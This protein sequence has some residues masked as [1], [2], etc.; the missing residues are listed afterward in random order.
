MIG[1]QHQPTLAIDGATAT[2]TA[3]TKDTPSSTGPVESVESNKSVESTGTANTDTEG[4]DR[5]TP[6]AAQTTPISPKVSTWANV[7]KILI[8][9]IYKVVM[10]KYT[11]NVCFNLLLY[12]T[13][14]RTIFLT[15][16]LT[17]DRDQTDGF[18]AAGGR[19]QRTARQRAQRPR[20]RG[21]RSEFGEGV[22][23]DGNEL[24]N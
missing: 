12:L 15:L 9:Y 21:G 10:K 11:C 23:Q 3:T 6:L 14:I 22:P 8:S 24:I 13:L 4:R 2:A 18:D 1:G 20:C 19:A 7:S 16:T 17:L 5:D